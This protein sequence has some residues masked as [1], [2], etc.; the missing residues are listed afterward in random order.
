MVAAIASAL[1]S[2]LVPFPI[3]WASAEDSPFIRED[4]DSLEDWSQLFFPRIEN[5]TLYEIR[6]SDGLGYLTA[7]SSSSA[8]AMVYKKEFNV[9]KNPHLRWRWKIEKVYEK[10]DASSKSGDDFTARVYVI[11]KYDPEGAPLGRRLKYGIARGIYGEYPPDS[12]LNYIWANREHGARILTSPF[13]DRSKMVVVESGPG[14]AGQWVEEEADILRD[15]REAFG[16]DP[17]RTASL[18]VMNDSDNTGESSVSYIDY[19]EVA[20]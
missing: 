7:I 1:L 12:S 17:P 4:F 2:V 8:S 11:F 10:G 18:A 16:H 14:K 5:H 3:P 19:I 6:V 9:L 15:Y 13:S 20:P